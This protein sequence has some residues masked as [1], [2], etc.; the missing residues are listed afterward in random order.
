MEKEENMNLRRMP[1]MEIVLGV[2]LIISI[3]FFVVIIKKQN[4]TEKPNEEMNTIYIA[5]ELDEDVYRYFT[6]MDK[7]VFEKYQVL[8][9][10]EKAT[11]YSG[12]YWF[13]GN[14]YEQTSRQVQA[15][16]E[17]TLLDAQVCDN[18]DGQ[19][20]PNGKKYVVVT[21]NATNILGMDYLWRD[22]FLT[23]GV[24]DDDYWVRQA[25]GPDRIEYREDMVLYEEYDPTPGGDGFNPDVAYVVSDDTSVISAFL[26]PK[27]TSFTHRLGYLISEEDIESGNLVWG[28]LTVKKRDENSTAKYYSDGFMYRIVDNN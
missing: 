10:G 27:D 8:N 14:I 17:L 26:F 2:V 19:Q 13:P 9:I 11:F 12:S 3:V 7:G 21:F 20:A 4:Y 25:F 5:Q 24:V 6:L 23:M 22:Y 28:S 18:F 16:R 15:K 1:L